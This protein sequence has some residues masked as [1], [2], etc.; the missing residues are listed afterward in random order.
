MDPHWV[1]VWIPIVNGTWIPL[2]FPTFWKENT[3]SKC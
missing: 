2:I 1:G 3:S